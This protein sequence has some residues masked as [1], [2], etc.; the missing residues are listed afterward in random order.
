MSS[1]AF[2]P[3]GSRI[4]TTS[5]DHATHVWDAERGDEITVLR[6]HEGK[7]TYASFSLDGSRILTASDDKTAHIWDVASGREITEYEDDLRSATFSRDGSRIV[8]ASANKTV[9]IWDAA[10]GREITAL[11]IHLSWFSSWKE[12]AVFSS[13]GSR[14]ITT[15]DVGTLFVDAATE[16]EIT[17]YNEFASTVADGSMIVDVGSSTLMI[18]DVRFATMS[19][20]RSARRN[21][22]GAPARLDKVDPIRDAARQLRRRHARDRCLRGCGIAHPRFNPSGCFGIKTRKDVASLDHL[23]GAAE[24]RRW[25]FDAERSRSLPID[26]QIEF[27]RSVERDNFRIGTSK[28]LVDKA[29]GAAKDVRK[30]DRISHQSAE[31]NKFAKRINCG[32][33]AFR[34]P[35]D[36]RCTIGDVLNFI[37]YEERIC[38][39][40]LHR[41]EDWLVLCLVECAAQ[42]SRLPRKPGLP[43]RLSRCLTALTFPERSRCNVTDGRQF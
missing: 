36:N 27:G 7:V 4:V 8:T 24:Q 5:D 19:T 29:G 15:S 32:N 13:N 41:P 6:G 34:G 10:S 23:V 37:R 18:R 25:H 2:S 39:I 40:F 20:K 14:I 38:S 43:G 31:L 17:R 1:A 33:P 26:A 42:Q 9:H 12:S 22:Q 30:L 11:R 3:D 35:F 28:N 16:I 21:L